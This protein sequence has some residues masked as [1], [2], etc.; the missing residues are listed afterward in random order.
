MNTS[1]YMQFKGQYGWVCPV[2]GRVLSPWTPE[3][4]CKGNPQWTTSTGTSITSTTS[5]PP[6]ESTTECTFDST[7]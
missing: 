6:T 7:D 2:C 5:T 4:P 1:G 3:C